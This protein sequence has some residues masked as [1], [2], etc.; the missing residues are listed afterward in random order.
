MSGS[1]F[2]SD[3]LGRQDEP[4]LNQFQNLGRLELPLFFTPFLI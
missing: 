1:T 3:R 4:L 2:H